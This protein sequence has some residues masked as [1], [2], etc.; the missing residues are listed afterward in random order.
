M[1]VR[2]KVVG[3]IIR[4]VAGTEVDGY[5][6]PKHIVRLLEF[7]AE[8][9]YVNAMET[10]DW[11]R[12]MHDAA[13][14]HMELHDGE[15]LTSSLDDEHQ[16]GS[17][18]GECIHEAVIANEWGGVKSWADHP[19]GMR[20]RMTFSPMPPGES[21]AMVASIAGRMRR[22]DVAPPE[23]REED[24]HLNGCTE[25]GRQGAYRM[26]C[27][28]ACPEYDGWIEEEAAT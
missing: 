13:T 19:R 16:A 6:F 5:F 8:A 14:R 3:E 10:V 17:V 26:L 2:E 9:V 12:V 27:D 28:P 23:D 20:H 22:P 7:A 18:C 11:N 4:L 15:Y 1:P 25:V 21:R 24:G